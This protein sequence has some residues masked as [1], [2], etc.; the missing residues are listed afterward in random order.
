MRGSPEQ[1][2]VW[3]EWATG[4]ELDGSGVAHDLPERERNQ[5]REALDKLGGTPLALQ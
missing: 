1:I 2:Q 4:Q 3:L 5:R